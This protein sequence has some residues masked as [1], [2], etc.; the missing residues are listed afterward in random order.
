MEMGG[1]IFAVLGLLCFNGAFAQA[2]SDQTFAAAA[3]AC[4]RQPT[5]AEYEACMASTL[6][7]APSPEDA[8]R[9]DRAQAAIR[10]WYS[11][12]AM[13]LAREGGARELAFAATLQDLSNWNPADELADDG[14]PSQTV[15]P[16][17]QAVAWRR[18]AAARAGTD[19]LANALLMHGDGDVDAQ[20]RKD[21]AARWAEAEPDNLAPLSLGDH[22]VEALL[23]AAR[24]RTRLDLH[25]YD[26]VRWIRDVFVRIPPT[27]AERE[28][29]FPDKLNSLEEV[30]AIAGMGIWAAM[31]MP[32][33]QPLSEACRGKALEATTTRRA[34]CRHVAQLMAEASD[35]AISESIGMMLLQTLAD[36]DGERAA[37]LAQRRQ[38]DWRMQQWRRLASQQVGHGDPGFVRLLR[39]PTIQRESDLIARLLTEAGAPLDPP[40]DWQP[41]RRE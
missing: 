26:Q 3:A 8:A 24:T 41:P 29:M 15:P 5:H 19:V 20:V 18:E 12:M 27:A 40:A 36:S 2:P 30:G 10:A 23:S 22:S 37:A 31:A 14:R 34:D 16:A 21:A 25:A 9:A 17:P 4:G 38:F 28:A 7:D 6:E 1:R 33:F 32:A 13:Q 39:D 11:R 35:S